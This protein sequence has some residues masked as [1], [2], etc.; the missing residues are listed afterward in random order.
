[1]KSQIDDFVAVIYKN[2]PAILCMTFQMPRKS[3]QARQ[4]LLEF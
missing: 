2:H 4:N 3:S 1:L